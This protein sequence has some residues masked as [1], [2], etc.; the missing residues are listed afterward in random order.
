MILQK[1]QR[2]TTA[3]Q[4]LVQR[5][6]VILMAFTGSLNM[7]IAKEVGLARKQVGLWRRRWQE[8]FDALVAIE[9]REPHAALRRMI[10]EVLSDAPRSGSPGTFSAEQVTQILAT[11]C[12]PPGQSDRPIETWTGREL[13][14]EAIKRGIVESISTSQVNR[15][16]HE[17][18]LQPHR[19]KYWLNT[20]E[21]DPALFQQQVETVCGTY[22][23]APELYFQYNTHTV[24]VDEMTGIQALERNAK[25]IPMKPGQPERI[26]F[27]HATWH[28]VLDR[29]L[30]RGVGA[31]DRTNHSPDAHRRR[32]LLAHSRHGRHRLRRGMGVCGGQLE[33]ALQCKPGAIHR[34]FGRD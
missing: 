18:E 29:E 2:S 28:V 26:E 30:A 20:T 27:E 24:C 12:E 19:S 13:R 6:S 15:Y 33:H 4:R 16:L 7:N 9:C 17:S 23:E 31:D 8:S 11:A 14:D 1:I 21:K 34:R 5:V 10:E 25:T 3:Q 22:L 32:F